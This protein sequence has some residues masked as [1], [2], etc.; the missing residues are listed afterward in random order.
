MGMNVNQYYK[1]EHSTYSNNTFSKC[2]IN[3]I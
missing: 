2:L 1:A 3:L